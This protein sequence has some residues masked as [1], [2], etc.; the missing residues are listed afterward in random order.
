MLLPT[1]SQATSQI[2][3]TDWMVW[4][5]LF[6]N[7][8]WLQRQQGVVVPFGGRG[9]P[10]AEGETENVGT[11]AIIPMFCDSVQK[12]SAKLVEERV[13]MHGKSSHVRSHRPAD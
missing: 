8:L 2:L 10:E 13:M 9:I 12:D 1:T 5:K 7:L 3:M 4:K 6:R 11:V